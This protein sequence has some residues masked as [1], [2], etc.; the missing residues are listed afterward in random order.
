[1]GRKVYTCKSCGKPKRG[2]VCDV[3]EDRNGVYHAPNQAAALGI[4]LEAPSAIVSNANVAIRPLPVVQQLP[5][6]DPR[7]QQP[8]SSGTPLTAWPQKPT[9]ACETITPPTSLPPP[10]LAPPTSTPAAT[11]V[12]QRLA[13]TPVTASA[14][15][16]LRTP[17]SVPFTAAPTQQ[18]AFPGFYASPMMDVPVLMRTPTGFVEVQSS[19]P[20]L[21]YPEYALPSNALGSVYTHYSQPV[22]RTNEQ[23]ATL[24][25]PSHPYHTKRKT[26]LISSGPSKQQSTVSIGTLNG[27]ETL[28]TKPVKS[29]STKKSSST[30]P[31]A[32]SSKK[33]WGSASTTSLKA[34]AP[35]PPRRRTYALTQD[36]RDRIS[37]ALSQRM[38]LVKREKT[39][40]TSEN[41]SVLGST[42]NVYIVEIKSRPSCTCPDSNKGNLCKHI[43]FVKLKV[44]RISRESEQVWARSHLD[45]ELVSI[46]S[47]AVPD[48]TAV[49]S[50]R[51]QEAYDAATGKAP[52]PV[53]VDGEALPPGHVPRRKPTAEDSCPICY[54][55][56]DPADITKTGT[57]DWCIVLRDA[58]SPCIS[59]VLVNGKRIAS[60]EAGC[61]E[62][63]GGKGKGKAV[64]KSV[65]GYL[66]LGSVAGLPMARDESSYN[67]WCGY[68]GRRRRYSR[69]DRYFD[70]DDDDDDEENYDEEDE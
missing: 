19:H 35:A 3:A 68:S 2:H 15:T 63:G 53:V 51:V 55:D 38:F 47:R 36:V 45:D 52:E 27:S 40:Q 13:L 11:P 57:T 9:D 49:A 29:I 22:H 48:P 18:A 12:L 5:S 28:Q 56:F 65:E 10:C 60:Q 7:L 6:L 16:T 46:F 42:G 59:S 17:Q 30:L 54:E 21:N 50:K 66:N 14:T 26:D 39:S 32:S 20:T 37:R 67:S 61:D 8:N 70:D 25:T 24:M 64:G 33:K 4:P 1:M 41:F 69:Y 58:D 34:S 31:A 23:N 62:G 44:L 43:L